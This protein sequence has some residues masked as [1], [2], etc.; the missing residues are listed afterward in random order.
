VTSLIAPFIGGTIAQQFGYVSLFVVALAMVL[1]A[2]F[3]SL[4][5]INDPN[6]VEAIKIAASD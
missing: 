5:Y 4:R 3:V 1:G 6:T 2:L